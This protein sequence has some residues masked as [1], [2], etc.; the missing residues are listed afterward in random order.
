MPVYSTV[1]DVLLFRSSPREA[2]RWT[3]ITMQATGHVLIG[4][5]CYVQQLLDATE[6]GE[7]GSEDSPMALRKF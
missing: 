3:L 1:P 6:G 7:K 5:S 2:L 4:S